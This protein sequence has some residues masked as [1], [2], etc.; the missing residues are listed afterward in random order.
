MTKTPATYI[1]N[2]DQFLVESLERLESVEYPR[3][4]LLDV[5][6]GTGVNAA[7]AASRGWTVTALDIYETPRFPQGDYR[8]VQGA[9]PNLPVRDASYNLVVCT[10]VLALLDVNTRKRS[11]QE[12]MRVVVSGGVVITDCIERDDD[13]YRGGV[14]NPRNLIIPFEEAQ[15]EMDPFHN[16][17]NQGDTLRS[18]QQILAF[19]P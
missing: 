12:L 2:P 5:G 19:K 13:K 8:Y 7:Y 4:T 14:W 17:I 10:G 11:I 15:W 16:P 9:L 3:G 1:Q 18:Q 6:C